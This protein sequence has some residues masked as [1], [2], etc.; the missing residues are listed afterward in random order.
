MLESAKRAMPDVRGLHLGAY[1]EA[2]PN[3]VLPT[4]TLPIACRFNMS[5]SVPAVLAP[6]DHAGDAALVLRTD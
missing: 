1:S 4:C 3:C 5:A 6:A 2:E